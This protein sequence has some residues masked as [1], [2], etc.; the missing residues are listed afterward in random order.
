MGEKPKFNKISSRKVISDED[1]FSALKWE[2]CPLIVKICRIEN[3]LLSFISKSCET[4]RWTL[5]REDI[6]ITDELNAVLKV[7]I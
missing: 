1:I 6:F 4:Y 7:P 2:A 5:I 3:N